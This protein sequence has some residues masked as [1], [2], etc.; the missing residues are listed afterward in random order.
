MPHPC[1][2]KKICIQ[3]FS[4]QA[5]EILSGNEQEQSKEWRSVTEP[6]NECMQKKCAF[7]FLAQ[8]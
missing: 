7:S 1:V 3:N 6:L 2:Y 4:L 8:Q 5:I